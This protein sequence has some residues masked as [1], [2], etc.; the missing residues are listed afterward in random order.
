MTSKDYWL[1]FGS[2]DPA[3]FTGLSPTL[4][5]FSAGGFTSLAAPPVTEL[6]VGSG[7]YKVSYGMTQFGATVPIVVKADGGPALSAGDR[8]TIAVF[9]PVAAVDQRVGWVEDSFGTTAIDPVTVTGY[10]KRLVE[11]LEGNAVFSKS[12]GLWD[13]YS[14]GSSTLLREKALTNTITSA[15]KS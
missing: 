4:V 14:R 6:P 12:S 13:V 9:D 10:V 7:F 8:Y 1:V 11:W 5:L 3:N 15:T 2:G